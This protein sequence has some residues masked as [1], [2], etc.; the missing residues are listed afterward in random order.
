MTVK[1]RSPLGPRQEVEPDPWNAWRNATPARIALGR[2]G[3]ATPMAEAL[4]FGCAHAMAR[5]AIHTPLDGV[6][7]AQQLREDGWE[8]LHAA[9]QAEDRA[10]YL[11]RPDLGRRLRA[12]GA[13]ALREHAERT[14][15]SR[16]QL[17][18][19]AGDGLSSLAT[20]RHTRPFLEA[21]R[22]NLPDGMVLSPVVVAT[23]A[24][25]AIADEIGH[26]LNA[27][28]VLVLIGERPGLSSP[29]S[30]GLYLTHAP[31]PGRSDAERNCVSNVRSAGLSYEAAAF[32]ISWLVR[33]AKRLGLTGVAL[34]DES[35]REVLDGPDLYPLGDSG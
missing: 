21:L 26:L 28:M 10:T 4:R 7:L 8:V 35:D 27:E 32:K 19:V 16:P 5:D 24:R 31:R 12:A 17:A 6:L 15:G 30:L 14:T 18:I 29:D 23:Q 9:S 33:R 3:V 11:R 25:V 1:P 20:Q 22:R 34:K 2:A 13:A